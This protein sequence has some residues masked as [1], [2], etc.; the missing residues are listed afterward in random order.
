[1]IF[2]TSLEFTL[3]KLLPYRYYIGR[4]NP[5]MNLILRCSYKFLDTP[6]IKDVAFNSSFM[7]IEAALMTSSINRMQ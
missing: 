7:N 3:A 4:T 2:I 6:P 5:F 1:M